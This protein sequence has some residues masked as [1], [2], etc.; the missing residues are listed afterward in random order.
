M[1]IRLKRLLARGPGRP[2]A[3]VSFAADHSLV[4][5][6]SDT[7]KSYIRS[8]L[9]YTLGGDQ[10]PK[11]FPQSEGYDVLILE[12][13]SVGDQYTVMRSLAG[14]DAVTFKAPY[15]P[16]IEA[17]PLEENLGQLLV[18]LSGAK[19][20]MTLRTKS[21]KGPMTGGDLRHWFLQ[22]Q[23]DVISEK[24]TTG[25]DFTKRTQRAAAFH[26]FLTGTDDSAY[27]LGPTK[28]EKERAAARLSVAQEMLA[29]VKSLLP[30][31][32]KKE[33]VIDSMSR[34]DETL[35]A[36]T[37]QYNERAAKLRD[38]RRAI[39]SK[40]EQLR[41][42]DAKANNSSSM[43]SRFQLLR[44]KYESDLAR[45]GAINEG[46]AYFEALD[47][48]DCPLCGSPAATH[49]HG[50]LTS[51][52]VA[53]SQRAAV[54]SEARKIGFLKNDLSAAVQAEEARLHDLS[55]EAASLRTE[56]DALTTEER[57]ALQQGKV[58]FSADPS[59]LAHRRS[60]LSSQLDQFEESERLER[61]IAEMRM[62]R[63]TKPASIERYALQASLDVGAHAK[64]LLHDW[65]IETTFVQVDTQECDLRIDG[66]D[67]SSY[68]AGMR[69]LFRAALTIAMLKHAME[70]GNPHLGVV[71]IDSPLKS[72]AD[73]HAKRTAQDGD[74]PLATVRD[75]FYKWLASWKG[76]GQIV[77]LENEQVGPE[78]ASQLNM[79]EFFGTTAEEGQRVG[80]FPPLG[81]SSGSSGQSAS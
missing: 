36:L 25:E 58:E 9:W 76:P 49:A 15:P 79:T 65:G 78:I 60:E 48:I 56:L 47:P 42:I 46:V 81:K 33:E 77:I 72:Y 17:N 75:R 26:V 40:A 63:R 29:R 57:R 53:A 22:S 68:G 70:R 71:V 52:R 61:E 13:E 51:P 6:P 7:G 21:R 23:T 35:A 24:P 20:L 4:R 38:V 54:S 19:G 39:T 34:V 16:P 45:L 5:G 44:E 43:V 59:E 12:F 62:N 10:I 3:E 11:G 41:A 31:E 80:F 28:A 55:R 14:G 37:L 74:A 64:Q 50:H 67:R 18:E 69:A 2:D 1:A 32:L 73:P 8:S 30:N 27:V 66:R